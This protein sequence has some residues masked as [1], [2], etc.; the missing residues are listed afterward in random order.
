M[1]YACARRA[2]RSSE[3]SFLWAGV[4]CAF[5]AS[6]ASICRTVFTAN[7][8]PACNDVCCAPTGPASS[9]IASTAP[10]SPQH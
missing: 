2:G 8:P 6:R 7:L 10:S 1:P 9:G 5:A 4:R 3:L